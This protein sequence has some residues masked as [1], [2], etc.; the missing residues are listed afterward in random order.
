MSI[1]RRDGALWLAINRPQ[2]ANALNAAVLD[3]LTAQLKAV[4]E[5]PDVSAV[6]L[7]GTGDRAFCSGMD[8]SEGTS[9]MVAA[10][11]KPGLRLVELCQALLACPVPLVAKVNGAC[12]AGGVGLAAACDVVLAAEHAHFALPETRHAMFPFA[13]AAL[14]RQKLPSNLIS[15]LCFCGRRLSAAEAAA[16]GL[17][18]RVVESSRLDDAASQ[19]VA[20][21]GKAPAGVIRAGKKFLRETQEM[22][23]QQALDEVAGYLVPILRSKETED[24]LSRFSHKTPPPT[25]Q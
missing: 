4:N 13:V 25:G 22:H 14:L 2:R 11:E 1:E 23:P 20:E 15:E 3:V 16:F 24:R 10:G 19:M 12:V 8:L 5:T 21:I 6:V 9:Y 17:V 18:N 7:G